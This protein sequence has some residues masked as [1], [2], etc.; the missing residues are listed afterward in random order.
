MRDTLRG[1][2]LDVLGLALRAGALLVVF[3]RARFTV[4]RPRLTGLPRLFGA[5]RL[6]LLGFERLLLA[7]FLLDFLL[8]ERLR[9]LLE[10]LRLV[11]PPLRP[12]RAII[13]DAST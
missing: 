12:R 9:P 1:A 2:A 7:A 10:R 8:L 3:V 4:A 13:Y 5:E 6:R 11:L